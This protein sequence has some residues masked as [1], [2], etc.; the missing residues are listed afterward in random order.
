LL[1]SNATDESFGGFNQTP[2]ERLLPAQPSGRLLT[3]SFVPDLSAVG[4]RHP[5]TESLTTDMPRDSWGPWF[6]QI[7]AQVTNGET[8]M[9]GINGAPLLVLSHVGKGRVAQFLSDQFWLWA[10]GY[11]KGGPQ[12]ELLRRV[13]HWLVQEP[14]LDETALH[15]QSA[16]VGDAWQ[17]TIT[18]RSLHDD[19]AD[20]MVIDAHDKATHVT[21]TPSD[22][23]GVL[24]AKVP[25]AEPGLYRIKDGDR[26]LMAIAGVTSAPEFGAMIATEDKVTP[27]TK[28]SGGAIVWLQDHP[29]APDIKRT[30]ADASQQGWG[31]IGLRR[32]G[33]YRVTGS[34]AT[35]L[36]PAW[37][38]LAILLAVT[39]FIWRREGRS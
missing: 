16:R 28:A 26:E 19:Q 6:R 22:Q 29:D 21:L 27:V 24:A 32:N 4:K 20:I 30:D 1:I 2:I 11:Q 18:K 13:A 10:R 3:G 12:A 38:A 23:P 31:W 35:P 14:E 5:V 37:A 15:G 36:W 7:D 34:E 39:A 33:Q 8:L 9:T 17:L 25:V